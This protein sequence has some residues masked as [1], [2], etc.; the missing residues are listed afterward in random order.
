[1][2]VKPV[3]KI[4][5]KSKKMKLLKSLFAALL[6][7]LPFVG[8][9]Q[10]GPPAPSSGMWAIIDTTYHL[11]TTTQGYT[12]ARLT[13]KNNT[14][15]PPTK[16]TGVQFRVFYDKIA[17]QSATVALVNSATN[18]DLEYVNDPSNGFVT[19][20][21]V[22]TGSS[23]TYTLPDGQT[24]ELT[25]AHTP[26]F[27]GLSSIGNLTWSGVQ[28]FPQY[29]SD[30]NGMDF[31]LGLYSYGGQFTGQTFKF[32]GTFTNVT[33]SPAKNLK[34]SLEKKPKTGSTWVQVNSYTT[35]STGTFAINE[36][37]DTTYYNVRLSVKGDTM[38]V[39]N[40]ISTADAQ[41]I[42]QWVLGS[43]APTKFD[44]YT[45]DVNGS[46]NITITDAYGVFG[47]IAGRFTAWPNSVNDV[48]FF[49]TSEYATITGNP[50]NNYT[51]TIPGV[52]NFYFNILPGQPDSVKYYVCV[53][54]DA[55]GTGYHMARLTPIDVTIN[56]TP[57]TPAQTQNVIDMSVNYDFPTNQ[58]EVKVPSLSVNTGNLVEIPVTVQTN[59]QN[60][61]A[62]Q[63]ALAYNSD[64]LDFKDLVNSDKVMNWMSF[65]NPQNNIVEWGGYDPSVNKSYMINDGTNVFTLRFLAK[66]P[67]DQWGVSPLYT[68]RKFSGDENS[69][70]MTINPTNGILVVA[71]MKV[72]SS[73]Y[74]QAFIVFP[75]PTDGELN[76]EFNVVKSGRVQLFVTDVNGKTIHMILDKD[77]PEGQYIYSDN[78]N[79]F[80]SGSYLASLA[81]NS[82]IS[83][84]KIIKK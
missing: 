60:I 69:K 75:N 82:S 18:L 19:I 52:T 3:K 65:V 83:T 41:L 28:T 37:V 72:S 59:G 44:F 76:F 8:F 23:S 74:N 35:S 11:G 17:F 26:A 31:A 36:I 79:N 70:D 7:V 63:L 30:N 53:P 77:M 24:F 67:Q 38:A 20:T 80:S 34:L 42:N 21:L 54:G 16:I 46:K 13:L 22:Y 50:T 4:K 66:E 43:V 64:I 58:M 45:G 61:S 40:V 39:G 51:T 2:L 5:K 62:L 14:G 57:G 71:R 68:T 49:T 33:G 56:P 47:R 12:K 78:I 29:A 27:G 25:F 55:N 1:M 9:S 32:H 6:L 81:N 84:C 15:T 73:I 10:V 48:K